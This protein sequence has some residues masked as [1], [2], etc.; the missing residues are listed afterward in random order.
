MGCYGA[1]KYNPWDLSTQTPIYI[2]MV[3]MHLK[4][5]TCILGK[6]EKRAAGRATVERN[7][8]QNA[9]YTG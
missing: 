3:K 8:V 6:E 5:T 2:L 1:L 7:N 9:A 4:S